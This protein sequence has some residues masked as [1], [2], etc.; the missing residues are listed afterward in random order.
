MTIYIALFLILFFSSLLDFVDV[1]P[2]V[3]KRIYYFWIIV[4]ILFK[5]LR[6]DTGDDFSQFYATFQDASFS[7]FYRFNRYGNTE[8]YMEPG[9][10]LLNA[11]LKTIINDYN[12]FLLVTSTFI[13]ISFSKLIEKFVPKYKLLALSLMLVSTELFPVRQTMA[14]AIFCFSLIYTYERKIWKYLIS[15]LLCYSMH[16]SS[17]VLFPIYWIINLRY[18]TKLMLLAY[19]TLVS[20]RIAFSSYL[21]ILSTIPILTK[22]TGGLSE[23][24]AFS[25]VTQIDSFSPLTFCNNVVH[26]LLF[27]WCIRRNKGLDVK[28]TRLAF[29][30]Y[31]IYMLLNVLASIP[32]ADIFYRLCNNFI[33]VYPL[34]VDIIITTLMVKFRTKAIALFMFSIFWMIKL[35]ANPAMHSTKYDDDYHP[36]YSIFD[37]HGDSLIR[38]LP[39]PFHVN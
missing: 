35:N 28:S 1:S 27:G 26:I 16:R 32:G 7:N 4:F 9:Y 34:C 38:S 37:R 20:L 11:I 8:L 36:Y 23:H 15:I 29:N 17:I 12:F 22:L 6:W 13:V 14:T 10:V 18:N 31:Y 21:G 19:L 25:D 24:Y 3:K 33:I 39:W 30:T 5:G 2:K